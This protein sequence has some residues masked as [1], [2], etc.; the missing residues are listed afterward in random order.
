MLTRL[1][2]ECLSVNKENLKRIAKE[3]AKANELRE[4]ELKLK[5]LEMNISYEQL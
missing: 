2:E 4:K 5:C 1:E 3:L